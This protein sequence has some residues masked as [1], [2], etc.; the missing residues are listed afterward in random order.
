MLGFI[1]RLIRLVLIAVLGAALA[2]KLLLRSHAVAGTEEIDL[3][4]IFGGE[5]LVSSADPFF[6]G[7]VTTIL[8]GTQLDLRRAVPAPT[9]IYLDVLVGLGGLSLLLP[10][11]WKVVFDGTV[12][13]GG[14]EDLTQP[15]TDPD[16]PIVRVGGLVVLGGLVAMT[17]HPVEPVEP[18]T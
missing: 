11:G 6:G 5:E 9:G 1:F 2:A 10:P 3:V 15:V 17:R 14:F 12:V 16:A 13:A 4:N 8:G 18:R 7:K